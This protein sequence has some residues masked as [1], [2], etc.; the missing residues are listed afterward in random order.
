ML[1]A[2]TPNGEYAEYHSSA[3]NLSLLRAESL[4]HSLAVLR[5]I[6][7]G[8]EG[9]AVY[10]SRNPKGEPQ[11][12]RLGLYGALRGQRAASYNTLFMVARG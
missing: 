4:A 10:H 3:D 12:G 1:D 9:D 11:L 7:A 6:V 5:H 8:I 2:H